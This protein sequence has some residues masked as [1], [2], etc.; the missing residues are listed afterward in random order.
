MRSSKQSTIPGK[1]NIAETVHRTCAGPTSG[2]SDGVSVPTKIILV[3]EEWIVISRLREIIEQTSDFVV[4]AACRCVD[5]TMLAVQQYRPAV[6][7]L[8]VQLPGQDGLE[9]IRHITTKSGTKVIVFTAALQEQEIATIMRSG[10]EAIVFKHQPVSTLLSCL[11][12]ILTGEPSIPRHITASKGA[13]AEV[14]ANVA[15]SPRE[16]EVAQCVAA[17]ARNKEIAWQLGISEGTVKL[18]LFH[19]YRKLRVS[20]RVELVLALGRVADGTLAV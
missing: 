6:V 9:L 3:D 15:L 19:A 4:V 8:D 16:R 2:L 10:T 18:H 5:G 13:R 12:T 17:G 7:I 20:N 1:D 11:H 14:W